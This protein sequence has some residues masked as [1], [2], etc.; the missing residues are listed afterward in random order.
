MSEDDMCDR[1][2]QDDG[3]FRKETSCPECVAA[4]VRRDVLFDVV[5]KIRSMPVMVSNEADR[6]IVTNILNAVCEYLCDVADVGQG[7]SAVRCERCGKP[8]FD[9]LRSTRRFCKG[10]AKR[11]WEEQHREERSA[12]RRRRRAE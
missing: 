7:R 1:H 3:R 2:Q 5:L 10:C 6:N 12:E 4:A 8:V 11:A 9:A